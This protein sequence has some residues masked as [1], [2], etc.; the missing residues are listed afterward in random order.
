MR[1]I[2]P[3]Y[4]NR[5]FTALGT[6]TEAW[7]GNQGFGII[8]NANP[9]PRIQLKATQSWDWIGFKTVNDDHAGSVWLGQA[10]GD[11]DKLSEA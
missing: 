5:T 9:S 3:T 8:E 1:D 6:K 4:A 11:L 10:C 2:A 7:S